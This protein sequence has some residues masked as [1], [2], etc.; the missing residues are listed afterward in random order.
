MQL[1]RIKIIKEKMFEEPPGIHFTA[2][3]PLLISP[4]PGLEQHGGKSIRTFSL[5]LPPPHQPPF[6]AVIFL[7]AETWLQLP[8]G[9]PTPALNQGGCAA[10]SR[11]LPSPPRWAL[12]SA[13]EPESGAEPPARQLRWHSVQLRT[14]T[15]RAALLNA[16]RPCYEHWCL[17]AN[18]ARCCTRALR[19]HGSSISSSSYGEGLSSGTKVTNTC[20]ERLPRAGQLCR[21]AADEDCTRRQG[22][23]QGSVHWSLLKVSTEGQRLSCRRGTASLQRPGT[24]QAPQW[25]SCS[26]ALLKLGLSGTAWAFTAPA[27]ENGF[28]SSMKYQTK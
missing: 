21:G 27:Q 15:P 10:W 22:S 24:L 19:G 12:I 13:V 26:V 9:P 18:I 4:C 20:L 6:H 1:W 17:H 28:T 25:T 8:L 7:P 2:C 5:C 16:S 23:V 11:S 3:M 14:I